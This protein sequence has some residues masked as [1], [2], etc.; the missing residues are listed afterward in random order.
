MHE[1]TERTAH[2]L[3]VTENPP[4]I[5]IAEDHFFVA[6]DCEMQLRDAG[7]DCVGSA[8]TV[9]EVVDL[10]VLKHPDL[11]LMDIRLAHDQSGILAASQIYEQ[12]GIR[13]VFCSGHADAATRAEA[14]RACPIG[15]LDKPY[16]P[17]ALI[18]SVREALLKL[19]EP[20]QEHVVE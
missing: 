12:L 18:S 15:W 7:F 6:L 14:A 13:S 16:T 1:G 19:R 10:A 5:L 11:I 2:G 3:P 8:S 17:D 4:R 9:T 20:V